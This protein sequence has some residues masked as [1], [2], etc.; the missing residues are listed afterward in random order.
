MC[1]S[2]PPLP[3]PPLKHPNYHS[4]HSGVSE[5]AHLFLAGWKLPQ[6]TAQVVQLVYDVPGANGVFLSLYYATFF[7]TFF[8][9]VLFQ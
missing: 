3:P 5:R 1:E 8:S 4:C 2:M 9:V 6:D 7:S